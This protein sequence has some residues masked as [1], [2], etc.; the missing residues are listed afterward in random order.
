MAI[1]VGNQTN[2]CSNPAK[3]LV[4]FEENNLCY[5]YKT[6]QWTRI[7]GYSGISYFSINGETSSIGLVRFSSGSVDLQEQFYSDSQALS[8]T[9]QIGLTDFNPGGR[10]F[11]SGVRPLV[12]GGTVTV[13]VSWNDNIGDS[14]A[15]SG[16]ESPNSRSGIV[17]FRREGRYMSFAVQVSGGFETIIGADLDF[18]PVGKV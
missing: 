4:H 7:P 17:N 15:S 5:N 3:G 11:I 16:S 14:I 10:T 6:N 8:A 2:V 18:E 1:T 13:F 9:V 12:S